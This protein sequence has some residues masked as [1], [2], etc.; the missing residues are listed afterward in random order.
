M[1]TP[2]TTLLRFLQEENARLQ[3]ENKQLREELAALRDYLDGLRLLQQEARRM[4]EEADLMP[5]LDKILY[6]ALTVTDA[7]DGSVLLL[8]P[9]TEELV[10]AVVHGVIREQLVGYRIPKET[11]IAGWVVTHGSPLIVN[12]PHL[13]RRFSRQ[14]DEQF[15]FKTRSLLCVPMIGSEGRIVGAIEVL[16]KFSGR[17]FTQAD[18][19]LLM[20]MG[21]I[22]GSALEI[23]LNKF[24]AQ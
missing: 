15:G 13:D 1:S 20:V 4:T 7:A 19:D 3:E 8:D 2:S 17:E 9:E 22:A 12:R 18:Q 10:F 14:V 23:V 24:E 6:A 11:G 16:N 5:L 21:Y